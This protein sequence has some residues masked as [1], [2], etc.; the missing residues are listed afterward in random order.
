MAFNH[1]AIAAW[2]F[3]AVTQ[4]LSEKNCLFYAL[5]IGMGRDPLDENELPFVF[6]RHLRVVPTMAAVICTPGHWVSDPR[7]GIDQTRIFHGEQ[8]VEFHAPIP[9]EVPLTGRSTVGG[10]VDKGP[11]NGALIIIECPVIDEAGNAIFTVRRSAFLKGEGGFGGRNGPPLVAA[12]IPDRPPDHVC[13]LPTTGQQALLYRLNDD[14]FDFHAD[15]AVARRSG[16]S[17]PILHGLCTY[18]IAGHALLKTV[19]GYD[20]SRIGR[21]GVRFSSPVFPGDAIRTEIWQDEAGA[22]FRCRVVE[23]DVVVI[24]S[25]RLDFK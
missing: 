1:E 16:F 24:G 12:P 25:G 11:G 23:R 9:V 10:I 4:T 21:L 3:P 18:G 5:S 7:T 6:E 8:S 20:E 13:D 19:C 2:D 17:Q 15:P 14:M 22:S